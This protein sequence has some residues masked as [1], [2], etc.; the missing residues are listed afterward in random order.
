MYR[1]VYKLLIDIN[2][3]GRMRKKEQEIN[4][5][6][7]QLTYRAKKLKD[8]RFILKE[9]LSN[10]AYSESNQELQATILNNKNVPEWEREII[11]KA[12]NVKRLY[13]HELF[14]DLNFLLEDMEN[15][16]KQKTNN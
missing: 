8:L 14:K 7:A 2:F 12:W 1:N 11:D 5:R 3:R 9:C 4:R 6:V 13:A 10:G 16:L 15:E